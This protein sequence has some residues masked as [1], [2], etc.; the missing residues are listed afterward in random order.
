MDQNIDNRHKEILWDLLANPA[1]NGQ[2]HKLNLERLVQDNPQSGLLQ[3]MYAR[4]LQTPDIRKAA[5]YFS[6]KALHK[7]LHD[8][9]GL[10]PVSRDR[11]NQTFN[12]NQTTE[13]ENYFNIGTATETAELISDAPV[14]EAETLIPQD[15]AQPAA[16]IASI[17]AFTPGQDDDEKTFDLPAGDI[18]AE[19]EVQAGHTYDTPPPLPQS[20]Q[21]QSVQTEA[22]YHSTASDDDDEDAFANPWDLSKLENVEEIAVAEPEAEQVEEPVIETLPKPEA[23]KAPETQSKQVAAVTPE[24]PK[25]ETYDHSLSAFEQ[26]AVNQAESAGSTE[27]AEVSSFESYYRPENVFHKQDDIEDEIYDEIVS[28]DE[29]G[30]ESL[31][32]KFAEDPEEASIEAA[33]PDEEATITQQTYIDG[34]TDKLIYG[35]I[36]ATDYLSFDKKLDELR[37]GTTGT[38][39]QP[40]PVA[41]A[42]PE[43]EPQ[44]LPQISGSAKEPNNI[45][46]Y[47]DD[48]LPYS[49]MWWLDK[50][51]KEHAGVNQPYAEPEPAAQTN[52]AKRDAPDELQQQYY[53]NIFSLTSISGIGE[54]EPPQIEFDHSKKE[55]IIIERFI[56]T[57]PQIKPLSADKLDNENKAKRSSEDQ[58]AMVT[59]TLAR[60]YGDQMLYHKAIA[61]YKNL[62]LKIPEKK[63]Y[64]AAQ[65]EQLEKKIN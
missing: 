55:D 39:P 46:K 53:T 33:D 11:V 16:N 21:Q 30:V 25:I 51:R 17:E 31:S 2:L 37:A 59:E 8:P 43:T 5:A 45:S 22:V 6:P 62:M 44:T 26:H 27:P 13:P 65:I 1:E 64:F 58:D 35:N 36:A 38:A 34:E 32:N 19:P 48:T 61:T 40:E 10:L 28:I 12:S 50:T 14:A 3:V 49:F 42:Q 9:D 63:L 54:I 4:S 60:I 23:E 47:N 15:F 52:D 57:D 20:D 24:E 7:L 18:T 41:Q 29:I 56:H